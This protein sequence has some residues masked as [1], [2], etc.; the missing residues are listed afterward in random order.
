MKIGIDA[1]LLSYRRGMGNFLYN[2]LV[3][4]QDIDRENH[5]VLYT[6]RSIDNIIPLTVTAKVR[7][8]RLPSYPLWEQVLL[9]AVVTKDNLD[10]LHCPANTGPLRVP[11]SVKLILTIHDVM[12]MLND[13]KFPSSPSLYQ[14]LGRLYR[15]FIVPRVARRANAILTDSHCSSDDIKRHLEIGK[16]KLHVVYGAPNRACRVIK[17]EYFL[18]AVQAKYGLNHPFVLSL[19]GIDPRKNTHRVI[20]AFALLQRSICKDCSLV[21]VGLSS[22]AQRGFIKA[23]EKMGLTSRVAFTGFVPEE[24]LVALYNLAQ[25]FV[26]PSL[27][28]GFGL[29]VLEAMACGTPVVASRRGS[30]PEVAGDAA[31]FVNP[32]DPQ[33]ICEGVAQFLTDEEQLRRFRKKGLE[34][35]NSFSW[36]RA[37]QETLKV[38]ESLVSK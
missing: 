16:D 23:V 19:A 1:R 22:L 9:P 5:Y 33:K 3:E 7:I 15:S 36:E 18:T 6:D 2:L 17:D 30:I 32:L 21:L 38:Y 12:F 31:F 25:V 20:E 10:M 4:L 8:I 26:Y 29:P 14:R 34:R 11:R 35:V 24:D 37:A 13:D 28:E 27:Y